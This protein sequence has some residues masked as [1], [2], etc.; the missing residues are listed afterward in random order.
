MRYSETVSTREQVG[1][2]EA[3]FREVNERIRDVSESLRTAGGGSGVEFVCECS[4]TD[5]HAPIQ[6][7]LEEYESVR[8][9]P[10]QFVVAPEHVWDEGAEHVVA[11]RRRYWVVEKVGAAASEDVEADPRSR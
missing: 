6:L 7:D 8:E 10:A 9:H 4:R 1:R 11:E 3:L 2:K 5:C